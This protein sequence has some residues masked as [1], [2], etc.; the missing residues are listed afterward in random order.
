[1]EGVEGAEFGRA[2]SDLRLGV[3]FRDVRNWESLFWIPVLLELFRL[4]ED[5][6]SSKGTLLMADSRSWTPWVWFRSCWIS[7]S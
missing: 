4:G 5:E 3:D 1:M 7:S 2:G 6:R